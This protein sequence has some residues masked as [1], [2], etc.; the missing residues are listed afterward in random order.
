M[1][2]GGFRGVRFNFVK[3]LV[4]Q[5]AKKVF[6]SILLKRDQTVWL[7]HCGFFEAAE[8]EEFVPFLGIKSH[9]VVNH[10][11]S[12]AFANGV[13]HPWFPNA[14]LTFMADNDNGRL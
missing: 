14:L 12:Q 6:F 10:M 11:G 5:H 7:A 1:H 4:E 8:L 9:I 2:A 13:D 3:R